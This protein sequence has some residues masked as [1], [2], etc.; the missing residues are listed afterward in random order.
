MKIKLSRQ[1]FRKNQ[2]S[3]FLKVSHVIKTDIFSVFYL[4]DNNQH[5]A[6]ICPKKVSSS[7]NRNKI[8]RQLKEAFLKLSQKI[9]PKFS[10]IVMAN[11][12]IIH[13]SFKNTHDMLLLSLKKKNIIDENS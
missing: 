4:D 8:K 3:N 7:P 12:K 10:L 13:S 11:K 2:I 6:F 5:Y 1:R 9:N